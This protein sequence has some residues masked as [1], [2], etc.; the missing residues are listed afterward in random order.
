[1]ESKVR[2]RKSRDQS[3]AARKARI[4]SRKKAKEAAERA[5]AADHSEA[6]VEPGGS[7]GKAQHVEA[8]APEAAGGHRQDVRTTDLP[9]ALQPVH[10]APR[11]PLG[12]GAPVGV[13][14][15]A[16]ARA[17]SYTLTTH[18]E[19]LPLPG[20][21]LQAFRRQQDGNDGLQ[22]RRPGTS[23]QPSTMQNVTPEVHARP[24]PC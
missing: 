9:A 12:R 11:A 2:Q 17:R 21:V 4:Q 19:S 16:R 18:P 10:D 15:R 24:E 7:C 3:A 20:Q 14:A 8:G 5:E 22:M 1:M 23:A 6:P 13:R